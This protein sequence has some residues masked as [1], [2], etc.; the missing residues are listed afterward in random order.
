MGRYRGELSA[1]AAA[2]VPAHT[3]ACA[4]VCDADNVCDCVA[5]SRAPVVVA[6][7]VA[8]QIQAE[9][10]EPEP[11]PPRVP[12]TCPAL[13]DASDRCACG[14]HGQRERDIITNP[15][16]LP[17]DKPPAAH[18]GQEC[19]ARGCVR[20][21]ATRKRQP[22]ATGVLAYFPRAMA[23]VSEHSRRGNDKH[24]PGKPLHWAREKSTDEADSCVRHIVDALAE[25]PLALDADGGPHL[26]GAAWRV[27]A[28][29]E[30]AL[31]GDERWRGV[32]K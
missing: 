17:D 21:S 12:D 9:S 7:D 30:R 16:R 11:A 27:L 6:P 32:A 22:I 19:V 4:R 25:G 3:P 1:R 23:A 14:R 15:H 29:L 5:G 26:V 18:D 31:E 20:D 2:G 10:A 24:N 28:W 8:A 13:L